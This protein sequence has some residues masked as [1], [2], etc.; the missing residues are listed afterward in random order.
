M[1]E[2][3]PSAIGSLD[4]AARSRETE[5]A[6]FIGDRPER[7][8]LPRNYRMRADAHYVDQLDRPQAGPVIRLIPPRHIDAGE[9]P[10]GAALAALTQSIATHGMLQPL[11]VRRAGAR[12]QLIA[13][14]KRLAAA[15][16][17]GVVEVPC[18]VHEIS[19]T[20]AE[21]LAEAER[22]RTHADEPVD[23]RRPP[24]TAA[25]TTLSHDLTRIGS[26]A[27][28]LELAS[29]PF[30]HRTAADF[31]KAEAWR[32]AWMAG[33]AG[34]IAT[35]AEPAPAV[36]LARLIDRVRTGFEAEM[37][38]TKLQLEFL[39]APEAAEASCDEPFTTIV[40]GFIFSTLG[41]MKG[42]E[43]PRIEVRVDVPSTHTLRL[44]VVQRAAPPPANAGSEGDSAQDL[45][46]RMAFQAAR[47]F[48][49][50]RA[51]SVDVT[52][53][54]PRGA[55]MRLVFNKP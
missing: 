47:L 44:Q 13:G 20:A 15:M 29:N 16:G 31:L 37:R 9:L 55:L 7:E 27:D 46:E 30:Q 39:V 42:C 48:A 28:V 8:G 21:T 4:D 54:G 12:Y 40:T 22:V 51:G 18:I 50:E 35:G 33:A 1:S 49:A 3:E 17:T 14:R 32:A 5:L 24:A 38:L 52:S 25:L 43:W 11:L 19:E 53:A 6:A 2:L 26:L 45:V 10:S 41:W 34:I 23:T 36:N